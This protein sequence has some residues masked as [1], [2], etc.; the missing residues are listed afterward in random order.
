MPGKKDYV[1]VARNVHMQNRLIPCN[2]RELFKAFKVRYP[3]VK[4]GFS[5][6]CSLRPKWYTL[7]GASGTHTVCVCAIHQN[8]K[9]LLAPSVTNGGL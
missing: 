8:I 9:L 7:A 2:I 5:K 1:S 4:I 6:F 3:E